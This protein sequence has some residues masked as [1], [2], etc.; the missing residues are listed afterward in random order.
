MQ[1]YRCEIVHL[2]LLGDLRQVK[3]RPQG[4]GFQLIGIDLLRQCVI[5]LWK[6]GEVGGLALYARQLAC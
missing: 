6:P 3:T 5:G 1:A 4:I 2:R